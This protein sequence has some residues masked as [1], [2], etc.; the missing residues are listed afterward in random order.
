MEG[1]GWWAVKGVRR[2][3][4]AVRRLRWYSVL[5]IRVKVKQSSRTVSGL[6]KAR[7]LGGEAELGTQKS[8]KMHRRKGRNSRKTM[9][10]SHLASEPHTQK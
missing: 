6:G 1:R 7:N 9:K 10:I 3:V 2:W 8:R 4:L 5:V